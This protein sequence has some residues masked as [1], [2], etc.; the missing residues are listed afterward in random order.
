[1]LF[2]VRGVL[3]VRVVC[4]RGGVGRSEHHRRIATQRDW[5]Q[6]WRQWDGKE[7]KECMGSDVCAVLDIGRVV[8]QC[9]VDHVFEF[10]LCTGTR[11]RYPQPDSLEQFHL[12]V[13]VSS[14]HHSHR[15][16]GGAARGW[17]WHHPFT[18]VIHR[19]SFLKHDS[20]F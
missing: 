14:Q 18:V 9:D 11:D 2:G 5:K 19:V 4:R 12:L 3:S 16:V 15:T 20:F 8:W 6:Q 10:H 1:V 7:W 13:P 17:S